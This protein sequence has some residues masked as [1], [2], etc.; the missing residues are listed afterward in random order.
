METSETARLAAKAPP[1]RITKRRRRSG[2]P[3][4]FWRLRGDIPWRLYYAL[5]VVSICTPFAIWFLLRATNQVGELFLP[6][7]AAV[8]SSARE[9]VSS[10]DVFG[11]TRASVQRVVI[12]FGI[13]V[14]ISVPLGLAMGSFKSIQALFEPLIGLVRYLPATAFVTLLIIWLGIGEESKVTLIIIGTVFFNT[15]MTANVVW[16]VPSEMIKVAYTLGASNFTVFRKVIF[17]HAMP[18]IIDAMRV[19]L[20]AAWNLIVVAEVIAADKG[21]GRQIVTAQKFLHIDRIF[22][23][24]IIIGVLGLTMD[25][26]LRTLRNR[27]SPWSQ[28]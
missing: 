1:S 6:T 25:I 21:L 4:T 19:N 18:G 17:P 5:A 10:G 11:D 16:Q 7:P 15:I 22:V 24:L 8:F 13:A 26:I 9:Y 23:V 27:I 3:S 14:L 12:G 20:A 28:A 2:R